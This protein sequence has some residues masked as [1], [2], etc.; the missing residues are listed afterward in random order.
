MS[1][2]RMLESDSES[3]RPIDWGI[4]RRLFAYTKPY[5]GLRNQLLVLVAIRSI[6]LPILAWMLAS[7][8]NYTV[9]AVSF[10]EIVYLT[11]GFVVFALMVEVCFR[12]RLLL[13]Y[14]LGESVIHDLR[15]EIFTHIQQMPMEFFHRTKLGRILSRVTSDAE[16]L[17]AGVQEVLFISLVQGGQMIG[18]AAFMAYYDWVLFLIMLGLVPAI[19]GL[20]R[21][22]QKRLSMAHREAQESFS[23]VTSSLAES[24]NGI[25]VTQ[26]FVRED[27]N[28]QSF[29]NLIWDHAQNNLKV[30]RTYGLFQP[31]LELNS[32]V[33]LATLLAIGGWQVL[34][35]SEHVN[36]ES[37]IQFFFLANLFF[38]P[39]QSLGNQYNQ[40]LT[41]LA[42]AERVFALLD[43][44]PDWVEPEGMR[45]LDAVNGAVKFDS[46]QFSYLA[47]RPALRDVSFEVEAG[48]TVALV[49]HTG[50]G[51][52]SIINLL[53][54]FYIPNS[55]RILIDGIDIAEVDSRSLHQNLGIVQQQNFLFSGTVLEN[56]RFS[57]PDATEDDVW[58]A[59]RQLGVQDLLERLPQG[60]HTK[61]GEKGTS[62]SLGQRQIVCF[63]RAV[64]PNP[65]ILILD[66]AT[67]SVDTI[68]EARLQ[69]AL[70]RLLAG[71]TSFVV[72]HRLS[73]IRD[74]S[75]ILVLQ[76][77]QIIERG[78]HDELLER[79]G[80]YAQ[81]YA[82]FVRASSHLSSPSHASNT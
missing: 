48:K 58:A 65:R 52:S 16:A 35:G 23:K 57:R 46:V 7:I 44:R 33:F 78:N 51:K 80:V 77:G 42:G 19:W 50:S 73:T 64:L 54:K 36:I 62:L 43:T 74:A 1:G 27:L 22:F 59:A 61:V 82:Q 38:N 68:T 72:A 21:F 53:A 29:Q 6:Q 34:T 24:V 28:A 60:L 63:V 15:K 13:A 41:A 10:S 40:L 12:Y 2:G 49:G 75:L 67:S 70:K 66:E 11:V 45:A 5:A 30:A 8:I 79:N 17:R 4:F 37:L 56:I 20:N 26:G 81:L 39:I 18:A 32:Q 31:L 55:G 3:A 47:D 69:I 9:E 25:R 76:H 14:R 71:R